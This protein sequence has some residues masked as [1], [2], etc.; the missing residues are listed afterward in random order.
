M[1]SAYHAAHLHDMTLAEIAEA[2]SLDQ[3]RKLRSIA[4]I[5]ESWRTSTT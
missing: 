3:Y 1:Y 4:E 5:I 2:G